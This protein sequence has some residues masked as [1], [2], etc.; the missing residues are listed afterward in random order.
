MCNAIVYYERKNNA[1]F[2]IYN[3]TT[4]RLLQITTWIQWKLMK[5]SVKT[6]CYFFKLHDTFSIYFLN[7]PIK[8]GFLV[9]F[10]DYL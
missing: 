8:F 5:I 10:K 7:V 4:I 6:K 3:W 2:Q 1:F 9:N